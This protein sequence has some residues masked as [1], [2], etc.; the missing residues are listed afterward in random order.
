MEQSFISFKCFCPSSIGEARAGTIV[1]KEKRK[2]KGPVKSDFE[3]QEGASLD[4]L[5]HCPAQQ[6]ES[7]PNWNQ[8]KDNAHPYLHFTSIYSK[9]QVTVGAEGRAA[10]SLPNQQ[11]SN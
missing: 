9:F 11:N 5:Q 3:N 8:V 10:A 7:W 4:A 6:L 1:R 2:N